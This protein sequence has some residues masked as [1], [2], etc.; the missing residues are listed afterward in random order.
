LYACVTREAVED[1]PAG[2]WQ[3]Q[4]KL[5]LDNCIRAYTSGSAYAQFEDGKKGELK[6]GEY[7]DFIVLSQD[8]TKATPKEILDTQVL[9]TVVGGR[10]VYQRK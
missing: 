5:P 6:P 1:G 4:E 10:T 9:Q 2:G 3:P 7:A 8:L